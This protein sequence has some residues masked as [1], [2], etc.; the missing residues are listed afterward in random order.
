MTFK[1]SQFLA[2][3]KVHVHV[4]FHRAKCSTVHEFSWAQ[5]EKNPTRTILSVSTDDCKY[6]VSL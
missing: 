4:K 6:S 1:F 5:R 2:V 3:V